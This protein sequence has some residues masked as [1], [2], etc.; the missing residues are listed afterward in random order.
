MPVLLAAA[1]LAVCRAGGRRWP[2]SRWSAWARSSCRCRSPPA[3]TRPPTPAPLV[4]AGAAVR[5]A[6]RRAR[7]RPPRGRARHRS[8]PSRATGR[9]GPSRPDPRASPTPPSGSPPSSRSTPGM[10]EPR[11]DTADRARPHATG[12]GP[13][14]RRRRRRHER[15]RHRAGR[16]GPPGVGQRPQGVRRARAA[17]GARRRG[18]GRSRRGQP[19]GRPRRRRHLDRDPADATRRSS[20]PASAASPSC[21]GPRSWPPSPRPAPASRWPAP[22]ARP[23]RRRCWPSCW[24]RPGCGPSFIIGGDVNE[25]G[26]GAVWDDG[27]LFVVEADESDGTFLELPRHA[28]IVTNVEPDHLE[29]YGGFEALRGR[30]RAVPRRD[31]RAP[32]GVRRRPA[33]APRS[34]AAAGAITY[35]TAEGADYRMVD[36][37]RRPGRVDLR[38]R[39]R[40]RA[41]SVEVHLPIA[42]AHNARNA[43]A[44]LV[45]R[46]ASWARRSRPAGRAGP[47]RR[48][49]PPLRAPGRGRRRHV[50]RRLRPPARARCASVLA[51][52][53]Q[54]D[55]GRVVCVFQP[56]RY[57]R[58]AALWPDFADAFGD[59]D[60]ARRDRHLPVGRGAPA[61]RLR[62]ARRRR[63]ARRPP[64]A[65]ARLPPA[66]RRRRRLPGRASSAPATSA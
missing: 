27:D 44:A 6:R 4:R 8:W 58:T 16:H 15:H 37:R 60:L 49:G 34:G 9:D 35:G 29:L 40:R 38:A 25:I 1:D 33:G 45:D 14:R 2:S 42:G 46:A 23:R 11:R 26:T 18:D 20:P 41:C 10:P 12:P 5:G 59:A 32:R 56:H 61:R 22:T 48:G 66:P 3:T 50:H 31:A 24:S 36:L 17:A 53:D 30:V 54:G 65:P 64:V 19:A 57:S 13:R 43:A 55:W 52:A 47:L 63:G 51:A 21:A 39:A 7:R 28:A 62:Q